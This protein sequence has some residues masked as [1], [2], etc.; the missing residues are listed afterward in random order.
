MSGV[1]LAAAVAITAAPMPMHLESLAVHLD[2]WKKVMQRADNF[3]CKDVTKVCENRIT[4]KT[5]AWIGEI[6]C[7][8][9]DQL[10]I[11]LETKPAPGRQADLNDYVAYIGTGR[12]VYEYDGNARVVTEYKLAGGDANASPILHFLTSALVVENRVFDP[13][14][15]ALRPDADG[16]F[17]IKL[18]RQD[19]NYVY[20]DFVPRL[21]RNKAEYQSINLVL[22][23]PV[24]R[25]QAY[26]PAH[27]RIVRPDGNQL[28][29][30]SF[31]DPVVNVKEIGPG[32]FK[33]VEPPTGWKVQRLSP[34]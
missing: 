14:S 34:P 16:R 1:C 17:E 31:R 7:R 22:Y 27:I 32:S 19:K 26:L 3:Y 28:E 15:G 8:K 2:G 4:K 18:M 20:L 10:R 29:D 23:K 24:H 12:E 30:W 11:R 9:P 25:K 33:Y 13:L 21:P 5:S 6:M